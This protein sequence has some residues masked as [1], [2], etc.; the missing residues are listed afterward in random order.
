V[1]NREKKGQI[2]RSKALELAK[3]KAQDMNAHTDEAALRMVMGTAR[4]MGIDIVEG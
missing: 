2:T 1:P 3:L 4:S